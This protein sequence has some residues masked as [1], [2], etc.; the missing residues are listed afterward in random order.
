MEWQRRGKETAGG[1]RRL[2]ASNRADFSELDTDHDGR[3]S[4]A[5]YKVG[6]PDSAD[7]EQE[8]KALDTNGDGYADIDEYKAGHPDPAVVRAERH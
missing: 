6:Y 2:V 5:E 3:L 4:L 1:R 7:V 8:F